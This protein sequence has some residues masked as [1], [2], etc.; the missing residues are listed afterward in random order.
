MENYILALALDKLIDRVLENKLA[1]TAL[2]NTL[3]TCEQ[4][5]LREQ[6]GRRNLVFWSNFGQYFDQHWSDADLETDEAD[7]E[8]VIYFIEL[9]KESVPALRA[10][11]VAQKNASLL[12]KNEG[13]NSEEAFWANFG[14]NFTSAWLQPDEVIVA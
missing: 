12:A 9:V 11:A 1:L 14:D 5:A 8:I 10:L 4:L 3:Q 2:R 7:P 6:T 13:K